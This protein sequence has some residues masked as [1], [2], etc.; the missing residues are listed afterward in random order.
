MQ[1]LWEFYVI[2]EQNSMYSLWD[3]NAISIA[4]VRDFYGI[5][6]IFLWDSCEISMGSL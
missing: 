4:F 3:F 6:M 2:S 1:F 5:F